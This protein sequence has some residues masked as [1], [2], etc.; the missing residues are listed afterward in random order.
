MI[1][2]RSTFVFLLLLSLQ[3]SVS[4]Q[5]RTVF[6]VRGVTDTGV[7]FQ[8]YL[9]FVPGFVGSPPAIPDPGD[10]RIIFSPFS[11]SLPP[12]ATGMKIISE[13]NDAFRK[14]DQSAGSSAYGARLTKKVTRIERGFNASIEIIS[15]VP[16]EQVF[17]SNG[18]GQPP[19]NLVTG[20]PGASY[21]P[22]FRNE[23]IL[24]DRAS[25]QGQN[26]RLFVNGFDPRDGPFQTIEVVLPS[27]LTLLIDSNANAIAPY[28]ILTGDVFSPGAIPSFTGQDLDVVTFGPTNQVACFNRVFDGVTSA[29]SQ[30]QLVIPVLST[31][32]AERVAVQIAVFDPTM[33]PFGLDFTAAADIQFADGQELPL[34]LSGDGSASVAFVPGSTFDFYGS[35]YTSVTIYENGFVTFGGPSTLPNGGKLIDPLAAL[36]DQP[37]IFGMQGDWDGGTG[38]NTKIFY[39]EIGG[40]AR[41]RW[42]SD[43]SPISHLGRAD[44]A[45][46]EITLFLGSSQQ[47]ARQVGVTAPGTIFIDFGPLVES[48]GPGD[49][50]NLM[51]ILPGSNLSFVQSSFDLGEFTDSDSLFDALLSQDTADP[52]TTL[53]RLNV[54]GQS[55][56]AALQR[57]N[58]GAALAERTFVFIPPDGVVPGYSSYAL[59]PKEDQVLRLDQS[60]VS[61]ANLPATIDVIGQFKY[62][63]VAGL[64]APLVE[65]TASPLQPT[66]VPTIVGVQDSR[67]EVVGTALPLAPGF[68][69][70]EGLRLSIPSGLPFAAGT[71]LD[72]AVTFSSGLQFLLPGALTVLP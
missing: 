26:A 23:Q 64:N 14:D 53:S 34:Q 51:G 9:D 28:S 54:R 21:N 33:V 16:L 35:T 67:N 27:T 62:L 40:Q 36:A 5:F 43:L 47:I 69:D 2:I 29:Q 66:F 68:R 17:A 49:F 13:L 20:P 10:V 44:Q 7:G 72:V 11:S 50:D 3:V 59:T 57:F 12:N 38:T 70:F 41:I 65:F 31:G 39:R 42:G 18:L 61:L 24:I 55:G 63:T 15:P 48:Q 32:Q 71:V 58:R 1:L 45:Q 8:M 30:D 6:S 46:F 4:G 19:M 60:T 56:P 37:A 22:T 25:A 52:L